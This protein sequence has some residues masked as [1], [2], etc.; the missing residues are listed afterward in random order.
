ML[1]TLADPAGAKD[2]IDA[3]ALATPEPSRACVDA[4]LTEYWAAMGKPEQ[5]GR[6]SKSL[7]LDKLP[8]TGGAV[9]AWAIAVASGDNGRTSDAVSGYAIVSRSYDAAHMRSVIADGHIGALLHSGRITEAGAAAER[10]RR[11]AADLP[12]AALIFSSAVAG[13]AA[14]GAGR[15]D[16]ALAMLEPAVELLTGS[17]ETNGFGYRYQPPRTT[18]LAI[19]GPIDKAMAGLA[20]LEELRH[21]SWRCLDYEH[22]LAQ[23]WV[24]AAQGA[25]SDAVEL[26]L[27]AAETARANGQF[28]GE[29]MCLQTAAQFGGR[30]AASRL[31]E[32]ESIVEGPRVGVAA[33][34]AAALSANDG[35]ELAASS[36]DF[37][38]MGDL[39]AAVDAAAHAAIAHRRHGMRGSALGCAARAGA[40]AKQCGARTPALL[41]AAEPLPLTDRQR[42]IVM[43]IGESLAT[44]RT[45]L[46]HVF[47][48]T[49][50]HRQ[51]ELVRLL[52]GGLAATRRPAFREHDDGD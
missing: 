42:E 43:L 30:A 14:L 16:A 45:H 13:R 9:T 52:L 38:R 37:E 4:F 17:G 35:A 11:Q 6:S 24:A 22:V 50:T 31:G 10:L 39:V 18:A 25:V 12:G 2:L 3:A 51:A 15:L 1:W 29:A 8:N 48:K 20:A 23:A 21:P 5:A 41:Q 27:S 40:L 36:E 34:Y 47:D 26:S 19:S 33:R 32:L 46:Q 7:T 44:V 49:D 28:A